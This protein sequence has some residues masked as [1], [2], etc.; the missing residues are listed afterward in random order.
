MVY[1]K[2]GVFVMGGDVD[3]DPNHRWMGIEKPKHEVTITRGFYIGKYEV[4]QAQYEAVMGGNPS[5]WREPNRPVE[6]VTWQEA[7]E[8]CRL[9][10]GRTRRQF[11]LPTEA[12]WEY[13][14]RAGSTGRYCFGDSHSGLSDYA[15]FK[16]NSGGQTHPVGKKKP[17]QWGLYDVHGNVWEWVADRYAADYYANSPRENPTGPDAAN[18]RLRRG[19]SEGTTGNVC[20]SAIR[21]HNPPSNRSNYLGFRAAVSASVPAKVTW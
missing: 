5:K 8:F 4:T 3:V 18:R 15:W 16:N 9:A 11:R 12:E 7:T 13:A 1:I 2:P 20:R 21:N 17:N 10:T 6:Q 19:G 14:C